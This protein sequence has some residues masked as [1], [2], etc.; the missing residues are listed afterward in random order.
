MNDHPYIAS[1]LQ[2]LMDD[3]LSPQ[4]LL[5]LQRLFST[6][7]IEREI[8]LWFEDVWN[9][10]ENQE[11]YVIDSGCIRQRLDKKIGHTT[12]IH[13]VEKVENARI[14]RIARLFIRYAA[15]FLVAVALSWYL[16]RQENKSE[17]Y[18]NTTLVA[19]T[20]NINEIS[21][22]Y[23]SKVRIMLPDSSIVF[24]NS[25]SKL[26]YPSVFDCERNVSLTGEGYF[27]VHSDSLHPFL[28]FTPDV[29]VKATGTE[30]NVK[31][32]P[33]EHRVETVL[34]KGSVKILENDRIK[35]IIELKPGEKA[36]YTKVATT[37]KQASIT[38]KRQPQIAVS[39]ESKQD[40][41]TGWVQNNLVFDAEP[42]EQ[43]AVRMERWFN[44]E[45]DIR[46]A[47]LRKARLS[48]RYDTENIE[49]VMHSFQM[50]TPFTYK[51]E[52]NKIII[53]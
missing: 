44:V 6:M 39:I 22:T 24:L 41:T 16:F 4:E 3:K 36:T 13:S 5:E 7:K 26:T 14:S 9:S 12:K 30:F 1:L 19:N 40:V 52:K 11:R 18:S 48:G 37:T 15:V 17:I 33:E 51:I 47:D 29:C 10:T 8:E 49:Q 43:I 35:P 46:N 20:S 27:I 45:I 42:F 38:V 2:K 34:V 53:K 25:G 21:V 28:V 31:A 23:G 50:T 32:Y